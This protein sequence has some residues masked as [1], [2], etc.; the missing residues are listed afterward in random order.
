MS[1]YKPMNRTI[2]VY[3]KAKKLFEIGKSATETQVDTNTALTVNQGNDGQSDWTE[4]KDYE[5][6]VYMNKSV[7][8]DIK[9]YSPS[10]DDKEY[11]VKLVS[12]NHIPEQGNPNFFNE[13][14]LNVGSDGNI[15]ATITNDPQLANKDDSYT[16]KFTITYDRKE[17]PFII[18]PKLAI[19]S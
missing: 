5:V 16:I 19:N 1:T 7:T 14:I 17:I 4:H 18:D 8:W 9:R 2:N 12:V 3:V 6:T 10:G 13:E 15:T 11:E